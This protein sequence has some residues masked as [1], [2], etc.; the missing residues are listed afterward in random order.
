MSRGSVGGALCLCLATIAARAATIDVPGDHATIQGAIDAAI[1]GD[2]VMISPGIYRESALRYAGKG[3][4]LR[5]IDPEDPA[6]VDATVVDGDGGASVFIFDGGEDTASVLSGLTITGGSADEGAGV[7][8]ASAS[9]LIYRCRIVDN[10][11]FSNGGGIHCDAASPIIHGCELVSNNAQHGGGGISCMLGS[12]PRVVDCTLA[13]NGASRG[14]GA[15]CFASSPSI[16]RSRVS[17]NFCPPSEGVGGGIA[18]YFF[19]APRIE[20]CVID[21]NTAYLGGGGVWCD[22][23]C[24][25]SISA[26]AIT[27]NEVQVSGGGI[28]AYDD[29]TPTLANCVIASNE[30]LGG[31]GGGLYTEFGRAS[32]ANCLIADNLTHYTRQGGGVYAH[33]SSTTVVSSIIR[34]NTNA[35]IQALAGTLTVT[36][37]NVEGGWPGEGNLDEDPAFITVGVF[38]YIPGR[39]SPCIDRGDPSQEDGVWDAH[40]LWPVRYPN[41]ARSD[42]GAYGGPG[43]RAWARL[44]RPPAGAS[45][46][47]PR[48]RRSSNSVWLLMRR[49]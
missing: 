17:G 47:Q 21:S 24:A 42:I 4:V 10:V 41:G 13:D 36:W 27:G 35:E 48:S 31:W 37:C 45:L 44:T 32:I 15:Y 23:Y 11:A 25:P 30:C 18:A 7:F 49:I 16:E 12:R 8:C 40:P 29:S 6:I 28:A 46:S 26:T 1:S 14:G 5:S 2:T 39:G 33:A 19:S 9:P 20:A 43:N 34:D 3:I 38:D 22:Y